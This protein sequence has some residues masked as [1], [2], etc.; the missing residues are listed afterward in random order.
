MMFAHLGFPH[1]FINI[2]IILLPKC[3]RVLALAGPIDEVGED[4]D[5]DG[6]E[7]AYNSPELL[8]DVKFI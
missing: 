3:G 6:V 4:F 1:H 8:T 5:L 7:V 2:V